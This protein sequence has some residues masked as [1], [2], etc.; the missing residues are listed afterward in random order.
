M[1]IKK[2][3]FYSPG[4]ISLIGFL[5]LL[6]Y[7]AKKLLPN[8]ETVITYYTHSDVKPDLDIISNSKYYLIDQIKAMKKINVTFDSDKETNKKK[9]DFVRYEALRLKYT[10]DTS[11]VILLTLTDS[12]NYGEFVSLLNIC[13][14]DNHK[15]F[16]GWDDKFI[17]L[18]EYPLG[19]KDNSSEITLL[20]CGYTPISR[21]EKKFGMLEHL[22]EKIKPYKSNENFFLLIGWLLLVICFIYRKKIKFP[23]ST[24]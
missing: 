11:T 15:R 20:T 13:L 6:P 21:E 18:G 9:I 14:M 19:K 8:K 3:L 17:I 24:P 16:G 12:V 1:L 4:L 10:N 7:S 23:S 2:R 5:F 22:L